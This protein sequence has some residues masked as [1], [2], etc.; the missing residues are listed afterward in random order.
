MKEKTI[1]VKFN[2][3]LHTLSSI[4]FASVFIVIFALYCSGRVGWFLLLVLILSPLFSVAFTFLCARHITVKAFLSHF[5]MSKGE[6]CRLTVSV[7]NDSFLPCPPVSVHLS[8]NPHLTAENSS[9]SIPAAFPK[10]SS[11]T[12]IFTAQLAGGSYIGVEEALLSDWFGICTFKL[13]DSGITFKT[14]V[15]PELYNTGCDSDLLESVS[16][17]YAS[18]TNDDTS[19]EASLFFRGFAGYDYRPY[20]PGDPLKRINSKISAKM[21]ELMVRLDERQSASFINVIL[22]PDMKED[23]AALAESVIEETLGIISALISLEFSVNFY[24]L[25]KTGTGD[26]KGIWLKEAVLGEEDLF[27]LPDLLADFIFNIQGN[28]ALPEETCIDDRNTAIVCCA[29]DTG[30]LSGVHC[31]SV[32]SGKWRH[33]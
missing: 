11:S 4:L 27:R 22:Y 32:S 21:D 18:G 2:F 5:L 8:D 3:S 9:L 25:K 29:E 7:K 12:V 23:N 31:Y 1:P 28:T 15:F 10:K 30:S 33:I 17:T 16:D 13:T 24:H 19:D 20:E 26:A 6:H 14:G